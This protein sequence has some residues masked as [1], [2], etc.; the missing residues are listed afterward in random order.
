MTWVPHWCHI[1]QIKKEVPGVA[2]YRLV[3]D[4]PA[5][6]QN[7]RFEPG[8][9]NMLY[10]PGVGEA[11]ISISSGAGEHD[12]VSHTIRVAGN[13]TGALARC[14][15][16]DQIGLRG[17][18]GTA[19]PLKNFENSDVIIACG[20]IGLAPLRPVI[21][22]IMDG[23]DR[24]GQVFLLYG[25]RTP[26]DL[27]FS[28]EYERWREAGIVV[29]VTVDYATSD[30]SGHIGVVPNLF[31]RLRVDGSRTHVLTCGPEIMMRFVA[32]AALARDIP[33]ERIFLAMERNMNCAI[34][35]C[36]H[37]Q[38]GP[39]FI[40]KDGPVFSYRQIEPYLRFEDL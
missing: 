2:T 11:A 29:N 40:C 35:F 38:L 13:V 23:R 3:F 28:D 37:C 21:Y 9:F 31:S 32:F 27:L 10:L 7:F 39:A 34:G 8:Q 12:G 30:W 33:S 18:F 25:S 22:E 15:E 26:T 17:P 36:G 19:W 6:A 20:G 24:Y 5:D 16:G 4:D 14:R 1:H